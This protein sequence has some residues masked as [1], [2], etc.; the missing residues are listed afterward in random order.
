MPRYGQIQVYGGQ[1]GLGNITDEEHYK[2]DVRLTKPEHTEYQ[3]T[4]ER[5]IPETGW[6]TLQ[7]FLTEK[8]LTNIRREVNR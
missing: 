2:L 6:T 1:S 8:E 4:I 7:L 5:W 3:L